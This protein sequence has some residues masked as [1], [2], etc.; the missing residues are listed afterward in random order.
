MKDDQLAANRAMWDERVAI[1]V[2][3]DFYDNDGF[4]SGRVSLHPM[5]VEEVGDVQGKTLLHLQCHF[6]QDA[7]CR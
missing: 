2:A 4:K 3:S 6:G 1:H 5:E 7:S